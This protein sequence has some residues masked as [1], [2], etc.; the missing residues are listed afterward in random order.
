MKKL[1]IPAY[2]VALW[3]AASLVMP[4]KEVLIFYMIGLAV[5]TPFLLA[6]FYGFLKR[7]GWDI[8]EWVVLNKGKA[9]AYSMIAIYLV[10]IIAWRFV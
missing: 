4:W 6:L 1:M 8:I 9:I 2:L 5:G 7:K 3:I 10:F